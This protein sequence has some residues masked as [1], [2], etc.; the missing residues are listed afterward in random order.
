MR[1][2]LEANARPGVHFDI[3]SN[4]EFLA[5]GSAIHDLLYPD[6]VL[7]GSR[8]TE[9]AQRAT[10]LL[11]KLYSSWIP[12]ERILTTSLWS[13]ELSKLAANAMLAQRISSI[14]AL[15]AI[16]EATGAD[17]D[18]VALAC[19]MDKRIGD[20]FLK[21]SVGFGGSCF[22]KDVSNLVYLSESLH[23][24]EVADYWRQVGHIIYGV[25][26]RLLR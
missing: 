13:S 8:P 18:E 16:C 24:Y 17:I 25:E 11:S 9:S 6:R 22:K 1:V 14:N 10:E 21:A 3:L 15:S 7:I 19:G 20:R 23:L 12:P 5:E 2:V 4:P 26:Y